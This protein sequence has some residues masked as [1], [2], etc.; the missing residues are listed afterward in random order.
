MSNS[1]LREVFPMALIFVKEISKVVL[2]K[3]T[4]VKQ[5]EVQV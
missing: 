4:A 2:S 3:G 5:K 1:K